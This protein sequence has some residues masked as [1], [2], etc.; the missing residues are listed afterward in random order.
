MI[1]D[2]SDPDNPGYLVSLNYML[3]SKVRFRLVA[4]PATLQIPEGFSDIFLYQPG[5]ALRSQL[6]SNYKIEPIT[7][8]SEHKEDK[9]WRLKKN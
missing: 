7:L 4:N 1:S 5:K 8:D 9:L 2:L 3:D 6:K